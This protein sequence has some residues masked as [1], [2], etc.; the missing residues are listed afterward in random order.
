MY[1]LYMGLKEIG[2]HFPNISLYNNAGFIL[3][4]SMAYLC[5]YLFQCDAILELKWG[6]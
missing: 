4:Y 2:N 3:V 5:I 6:K 1:V